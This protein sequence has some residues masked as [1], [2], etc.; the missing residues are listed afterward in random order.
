MAQDVKW[1]NR[2][3]LILKGYLYEEFPKK[4]CVTLVF[5]Q[6]GIK[7]MPEEK[8]ANVFA[9]IIDTDMF[10]FGFGPI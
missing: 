3:I 1:S 9:K 8:E 4:L 6:F 5:S 2:A 7:C 10:I